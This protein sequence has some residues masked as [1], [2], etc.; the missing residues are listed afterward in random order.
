MEVRRIGYAMKLL[1][2]SKEWS[3][4]KES[5][6]LNIHRNTLALYE[7][8]P[9]NMS[10]GLLNLFLSIHNITRENFFKIVYDNSLIS[11]KQA[12]VKSG[13]YA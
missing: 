2:N 1:R 12:A 8:N 6:M 9:E 7:E 3:L 5:Q 10:I 4:E 13:K 11:E